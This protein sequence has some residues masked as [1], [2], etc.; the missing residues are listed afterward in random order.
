MV[1]AM[2][3][4]EAEK[5]G[6]GQKVYSENTVSRDLASK[7]RTVLKWAPEPEVGGRGKKSQN[8]SEGFGA[9]YLRFA[10]TVLKYHL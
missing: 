2:G 1:W 3:H 8:K 9:D 10:R 6:R 7:A 4:P 5:G